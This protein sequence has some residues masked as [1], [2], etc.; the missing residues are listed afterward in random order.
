MAK[1]SDSHFCK[2]CGQHK[3]NESFSG[4][5]HRSHICKKCRSLPVDARNEREVI[6]KIK[7][8]EERYLS[9]VE[10]KWLRKKTKDYRLAVRE[11]ACS[12]Y[13]AKFGQLPL[14]ESQAAQSLVR[15]KAKI[16]K[17]PNPFGREEMLKLEKA[18]ISAFPQDAQDWIKEQFT[19]HIRDYIIRT[20][21][22]PY[23]RIR[24]RKMGLIVQ[25]FNSQNYH[26]YHKLLAQDDILVALYIDLGEALLSE[27]RA[28]R[29]LPVDLE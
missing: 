27:Y 22:V 3:S 24:K 23:K 9:Q 4:R 29:L 25:K 20:K 18:S 8:M 15:A 12:I 14:T 6:T 13:A 17:V 10:I 16:R 21:H 1:R 11:I 19:I 2:V 5:G 28:G 26:K 7:R